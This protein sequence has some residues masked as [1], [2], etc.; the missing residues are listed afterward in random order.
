MAT[1]LAGV[2]AVILLYSLLQMFRAANPA[3]PTTANSFMVLPPFNLPGRA[4]F[5]SDN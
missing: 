2:V 5:K 1:L 3:V 4:N